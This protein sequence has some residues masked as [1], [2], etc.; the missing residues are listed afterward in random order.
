MAKTCIVIT[1]P[2]ASGKTDAAIKLAQ[3]FN[4]KIISADSR[5]CYRELGIGVAKPSHWQLDAVEHYFINSHS[6][7]EN[8][9][10]SVFENYA[11]SAVH[12]IFSKSDVSVMCGGTGLYIQAFTNGLDN[13][14]EIDAA[15]RLQIAQHYKENGLA[16]LQNSLI[17]EDPAFASTGEIQNPQRMMR[18]L[19]VVRS[20]GRSILDY[21]TQHRV[22]RDFNIIKFCIQ[23]PRSELYTNINNRVDRMMEHGLLDEARKLQSFRHL[24]ALQT[25]GY[26][27]FFEYFDGNIALDKAVDEVKKN[28]RN[29]AKRQETWFRRETD[30]HYTVPSKLL[31]DVLEKLNEAKST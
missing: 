10:A 11:L 16:Y 29:Y 31:E 2:T 20:T 26:K 5:Q 8:V 17:K 12:Q 24:N 13:I 1:G 27:E 23:V 18:A 6:I 21:H 14:P 25:V 28:T 22:V 30:I 9:T 7:H 19:E 3:H 15:I 4:T